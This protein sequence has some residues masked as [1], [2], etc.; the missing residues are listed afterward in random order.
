MDDSAARETT[1][2][3][4]RAFGMSDLGRV[5]K[6][7]EDNLAVC[8]L[9][10]GDTRQGSFQY[11]HA[12][13]P[14]GALLMVADG[15][16]GEV[17][18][19]LASQICVDE[20]PRRLLDDLSQLSNITEAQLIALLRKAV[21]AANERILQEA[22]SNAFYRGMGSTTTAAVLFGK[23]LLVAQVGD[24][25]AYVIRRGQMTRLTRDQTFL[26]Y[27]ADIG[28]ESSV[29]VENDPRKNILTQAVGTSATLDVKVTGTSLCH[30]DLILLCSD[31]LY[32]MVKAAEMLEVVGSDGAIEDRGRLMIEK[33][34][35]NGGV[36]N[37]TVLMAVLAGPGLPVSHPSTPVEVK[38]FGSGA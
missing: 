29:D 18:G 36:D 22:E 33:A 19:E 17:C 13:G 1:L 23:S 26:N 28:A 14:R 11:D 24:S 5:R 34:N 2:I 32:N 20:V 8:N 30:D 16:G 37:I 27:L 7:N 35:A 4:V 21:H 31:G 25:R 10:T 12:L 6:N 15:M 3:E 9:S 38:E